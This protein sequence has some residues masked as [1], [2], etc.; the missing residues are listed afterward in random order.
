[1]GFATLQRERRM[2]DVHMSLQRALPLGDVVTK[3]AP[4]RRQLPTLKFQMPV[5]GTDRTV[6]PLAPRARVRT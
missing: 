5:P 3:L 4:K 6:I 2:F 1:M